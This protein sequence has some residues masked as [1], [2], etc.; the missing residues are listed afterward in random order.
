MIK[1]II[2]WLKGGNQQQLNEVV[3]EKNKN[4]W[5]KRKSP[6]DLCGI[7]G[8]MDSWEIRKKLAD[9]YK[10]HNAAAAS[11]TPELREEA[12]VMLNAI[13]ICRERY[14]DGRAA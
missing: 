10:R 8:E 5:K 1:Q 12:Q 13:V 11:L 14:V 9:L 7:N 2:N 6:E 3:S 4:D